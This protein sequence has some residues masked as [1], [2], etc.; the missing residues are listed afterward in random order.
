MTK[1]AAIILS[2]SLLLTAPAAQAGMFK[3]LAVVGGLVVAGKAIAKKRAEKKQQAG[4]KNEKN[5]TSKQDQQ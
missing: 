5:Q 1:F 2:F 4:Q 3:K